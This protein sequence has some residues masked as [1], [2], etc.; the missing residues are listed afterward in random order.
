MEIIIVILVIIIILLIVAKKPTKPHTDH[1]NTQIKVLP[2][3]NTT[4]EEH[5][6]VIQKKPGNTK[7]MHFSHPLPED[8][9]RELMELLP[10]EMPED[11]KK[12][13]LGNG[14]TIVHHSKGKI[15]RY[16][17]GEKISE[18][19]ISSDDVID[20]KIV[21]KCPHCGANITPE[22]EE[23]EYCKIKIN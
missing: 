9:K 18:E 1:V 23:C 2:T 5:Y 8:V 14:D 16:K 22:L 17:N 12:R 15:I 3:N 6:V 11:M 19:E 21:Q 20:K 10:D 4:K 13:I 7:T